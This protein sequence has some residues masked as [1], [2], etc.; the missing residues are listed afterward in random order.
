MKPL[1]QLYASLPAREFSPLKLKA[2]RQKMIEKNWCRGTIN[3]NTGRVRRLFRWAV[4]EELVPESLVHGLQAVRDLR[5]EE[6]GIRESEPVKPVPEADVEAVIPLVP[7][8]IA[9]MI[10]LQALTGMRPGEVIQ[11]KT[12]DIDRTGKTWIYVGCKDIF[13]KAVGREQERPVG[14]CSQELEAKRR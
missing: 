6:E 4:G 2:V 9:A 12:Q 13:S 7:K 1:V 10:R 3:D 8:R 14:V 11:M 5:M